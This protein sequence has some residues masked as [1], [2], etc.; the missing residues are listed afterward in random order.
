MAHFGLG[1]STEISS[2]TVRWPSGRVQRFDQL[3]VGHHFVVSE[4][5]KQG[6]PDDS[7]AS[8]SQPMYE[9]FPAIPAVTHEED[10]FDDFQ[11]QPLLPIKLSQFGPGMAW[12]DVNADGRDDLYVGGGAGP[13][14]I[15]VDS[16]TEQWLFA[17]SQQPLW[18]TRSL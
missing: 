2:A 12:G 7:L 4:P 15:I 13:S 1:E 9:E 16:A 6:A 10:D 3:P 5:A 11:Q 17:I 14:W 8:D 18:S